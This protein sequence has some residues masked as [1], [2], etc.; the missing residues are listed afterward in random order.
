MRR[1]R[2]P[3]LT[4]IHSLAHRPPSIWDRLP[5]G[6]LAVMDRLIRDRA[7]LTAANAGLGEERDELL[8]DLR[9]A[10]LRIALRPFTRL[11]PEHMNRTAQVPRP[12]RPGEVWTKR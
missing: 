11:W 12:R 1:V 5:G 10:R 7:T 3:G 9:I 6:A 4:R 8:E 2:P